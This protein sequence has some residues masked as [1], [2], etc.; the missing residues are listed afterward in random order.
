[1]KI[2]NYGNN[3][4]SSTRF[5]SRLRNQHVRNCHKLY[6][7][8][9]LNI[10]FSCICGC[11]NLINIVMSKNTS[12]VNNRLSMSSHRHSCLVMDHYIFERGWG[13]GLVGWQIRKQNSCTASAE[14]IKIV[15]SGKKQRNKSQASGIKLIQSF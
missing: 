12:N 8:R 4:A 5:Y 14:G 9:S 1:M 3:S 10:P 2:T 11:M 7:L 15:H 13:R 6:R